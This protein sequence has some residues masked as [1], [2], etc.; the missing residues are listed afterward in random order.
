MTY[1][2]VNQAISTWQWVIISIIFYYIS[3]VY[4][5]PKLTKYMINKVEN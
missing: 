1:I 2:N 3:A 5:M 4:L